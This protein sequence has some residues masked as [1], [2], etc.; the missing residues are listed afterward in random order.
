MGVRIALGAARRQIYSLAFGEVT[1]PL[2]VGLAGGVAASLAA[3]QVIKSMLFGVQD[4][5]T[6]LIVFVVALFLLAA[7]AAGY[8]PARR[9]A[10]VDP[11]DS[12]R[13]E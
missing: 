11:M 12:L 5:D 6:L 10:T 4:L 9:A 1:T 7:F 3:G 2:V 8:W 13:S